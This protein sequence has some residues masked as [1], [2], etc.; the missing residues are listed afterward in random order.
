MSCNSASLHRGAEG[1]R[2]VVHCA[3]RLPRLT[4]L[5]VSVV[6]LAQQLQEA[7]DVLHDAD[8]DGELLHLLVLQ[9]LNTHKL[10]VHVRLLFYIYIYHM[11]MH[12]CVCVCVCALKEAN[13]YDLCHEYQITHTYKL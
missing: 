1:R 3:G 6:V 2:Q 12:V 13:V 4:D 9:C 5:Q 7:Q 10:H 8:L 11:C